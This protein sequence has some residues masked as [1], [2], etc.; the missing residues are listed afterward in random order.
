MASGNGR[1][2]GA[3]NATTAIVASGV[4]ST[5]DIELKNRGDGWPNYVPPLPTFDMVLIGGGGGG[6]GYRGAGGGGGGVVRVLNHTPV[7]GEEFTIFVGAGGPGTV[8]QAYVVAS[9]GGNTYVEKLS[10]GLNLGGIA[11]GGG[12]GGSK[13]NGADGASGG[14]AGQYPGNYL[15]GS[16]I[17]GDQG[18]D[19]GVVGGVGGSDGVGGGGGGGSLATSGAAS[20]GNGPDLSALFGTEVGD[21]GYFAGGGGGSTSAGGDIGGLGGLGGGGYGE[22]YN[23]AAENG[24]LG[25]GGGG[26]GDWFSGGSGTGGSGAV[27]F[28]FPNNYTPANLTGSYQTFTFGTYTVVWFTGAGTLS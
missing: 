15:P 14:G 16:A 22:R 7:A 11:Y 26:G 23:N 4:F 5:R 24:Q 28:R 3:V 12:G 9:N 19:G 17:H 27:I 2:L 18:N 6:G 1:I 10:D 8:G 13:T 25:T 21:N 20:G